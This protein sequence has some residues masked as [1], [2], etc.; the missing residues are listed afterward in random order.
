[1]KP[2]RRCGHLAY[3]YAEEGS[4]KIKKYQDKLEQI[5]AI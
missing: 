1:M 4:E 2:D 5:G 3:E